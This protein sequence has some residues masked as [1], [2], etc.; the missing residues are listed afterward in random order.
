MSI[1]KTTSKRYLQYWLYL[2]KPYDSFPAVVDL[3][4]DLR[5]LYKRRTYDRFRE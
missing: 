1:K 5:Q 2:R 3:T 4:L